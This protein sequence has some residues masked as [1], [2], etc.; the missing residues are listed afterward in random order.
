MEA[1]EL[2][3]CLAKVGEIWMGEEP[4]C[5]REVHEQKPSSRNKFVSLS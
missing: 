3:L 1:A 4:S 5:W 2:E